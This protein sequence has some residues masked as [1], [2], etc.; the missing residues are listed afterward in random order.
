[1]CVCVCVCV[2][3]CV[4][5]CL[6]VCDVAFQTLQNDP[7]RINAY[8]ACSK[9]FFPPYVRAIVTCYLLFGYKSADVSE[10]T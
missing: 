6:C 7:T 8:I 5:V 4:C 1:M 10:G 3:V 9:V 2:S